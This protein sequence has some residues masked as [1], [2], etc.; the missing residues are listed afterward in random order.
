MPQHF[1]NFVAQSFCAGFFLSTTTECQLKMA[2]VFVLGLIAGAMIMEQEY[3]ERLRRM[4]L[5]PASNQRERQRLESEP[6]PTLTAG[7]APVSLLQVH[8][9]A[10]VLEEDS[11]LVL[12]P[13][14][15]VLDEQ[16]SQSSKQDPIAQQNISYQTTQA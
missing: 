16:R 2:A 11:S 3:K 9:V 5:G 12:R 6:T 10:D 15:G 8:S 1:I 4:S 14:D 7:E 13:I